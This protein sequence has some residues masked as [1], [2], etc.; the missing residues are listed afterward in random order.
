MR[1]AHLFH[2][3]RHVC[4]AVILVSI[5]ASGCVG[6]IDDP[7]KFTGGASC[8]TEDVELLFAETCGGTVCHAAGAEPAGGLDLESPGA[9]ER[10]IGAPADVC[11]GFE[12]V[13]PGDPDSSF[14]VS[15]L[16]GPPEGCGDPMPVVGNLSDDEIACV[17]DWIVSVGSGDAQGTQ[18]G[19]L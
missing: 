9:A 5:G 2:S 3:P 13:V 10:M 18:G 8:T 11:A 12:L 14:L 19:T 1:L 15:K 7:Q 17:R 6:G 4:A 16:E